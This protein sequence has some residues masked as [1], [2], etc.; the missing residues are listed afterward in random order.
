MRAGPSRRRAVL[1]AALLAVLTFALGEVAARAGLRL[2]DGHWGGRERWTTERRAVGQDPSDAAPANPDESDAAQSASPERSTVV[3]PFFGF[4][5][6]PSVSNRWWEVTV[7]GFFARKKPL[8]DPGTGERIR[9]A[10]LGGSVANHFAFGGWPKLAAE[11][12]RATGLPRAA[13]PVTSLAMGGY[14]QPQQLNIIAHHLARGDR[15]DVVINLDGF[16]ELVLPFDNLRAG[17]APGYP[18]NWRPLVGGLPDVDGQKRVG[19]LAFLDGLRA[20]RAGLCSGPLGGSA[21]CH[22]VW[23]LRDRPLASR[24]RGLRAGLGDQPAATGDDRWHFESQGPLPRELGREARYAEL[25]AYWRRASLQIDAMSRAHGIRYFH[26][27]QPN[28]YLPGS[29]PLSAEE[30]RTAFDPEIHHRA[31]IESAYPLLRT[32]GMRLRAE[33]VRFHDLTQ[34]FTAV[35]E[36]LYSDPCCHLNVRG[37]ELLGEAIGRI[38]AAELA[39]ETVQ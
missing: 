23:R 14:K 1:F 33:G 8:P 37:N 9:I 27:L 15:F 22:L 21:L 12:S 11:I 17:L 35:E 19:E 2:L 13:I 16:N 30:R 4:T 3:H 39:A 24:Q 25:V 10:V 32:E 26:F 36:T 5:R 6:D 28:Q 29:K 7:D 20:R 34:I 18:V 38:V 31:I